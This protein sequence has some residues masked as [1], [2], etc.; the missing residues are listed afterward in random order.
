MNKLDFALENFND[1]EEDDF[2][3]DTQSTVFDE[4]DQF[5]KLSKE[6]IMLKPFTNY[7]H[8]ISYIIE[9]TD[10]EKLSRYNDKMPFLSFRKKILYWKT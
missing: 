6:E 4:E 3:L 5:L 10:F 2:Y 9:Q 7:F 1:D 8:L